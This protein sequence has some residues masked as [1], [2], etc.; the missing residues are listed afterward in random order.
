MITTLAEAYDLYC[1]HLEASG[2]KAISNIQTALVRY[3]LPGYG[4]PSGAKKDT[5]VQF[6]TN[7]SL[8][9]FKNALNIQEQVYTSLGT[10]CSSA[11]R[12]NYRTQCRFRGCPGR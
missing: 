4:L 11:S 6:M 2:S 1:K 5:A 9:Q 3:T 12:R 10:G 8:E 7:V